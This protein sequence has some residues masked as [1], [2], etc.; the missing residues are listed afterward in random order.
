MCT[1]SAL[2]VLI[3]NAFS[4]NMRGHQLYH[5]GRPV[6]ETLQGTEMCLKDYS[7]KPGSTLVVTKVGLVLNVT[8]AKVSSINCF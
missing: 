2:R 6:N 3:G 5:L 1:V 8:N 4:H 7:I